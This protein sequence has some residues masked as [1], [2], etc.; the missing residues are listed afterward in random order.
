MLCNVRKQIGQRFEVVLV[1]P[2]SFAAVAPRQMI[3]SRKKGL[4]FLLA[5]RQYFDNIYWL[6]FD[7]S[8]AT[9]LLR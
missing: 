3:V 9:P 8:C 2:Y 7:D 6:P 1:S 4:P 5:S